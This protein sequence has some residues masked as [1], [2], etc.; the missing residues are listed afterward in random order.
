VEGDEAERPNVARMYDYFLGGSHNFAVDRDAAAAVLAAVPAVRS[1]A[2]QN[3]AFLRRA[4]L[5]LAHL[6]IRQFLD[7]GSGIPTV[8]NVHEI[9]QRAAP[10][11]RVVYVDIEPVAVTHSRALLEGN[12]DAAVAQL[13]LREPE[14]VLA[15]PEVRDLLDLDRPVGLLAVAVLH[16]IP[17]SD[18]PRGVLAA[19][20]DA[21]A[22]GSHLVISHGSQSPERM[23]ASGARTVGRVYSS[24]GT[25]GM[26]RTYE[27]IRALFGDWDL[28]EPGLVRLPTWRPDRPDRLSPADL[29]ADLDEF[30]YG[31]MARKP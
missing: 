14:Q 18:D 29:G 10:S 30:P 28:V 13:D 27:E 12:P 11:A 21:V 3:R 16:F 20:R 23:V 26:S 4:V 25:P 31:G 15:S 19:Y 8:G 24:T 22:P 17:D 5:H 1:L 6:G 9:A 7:L 2:R